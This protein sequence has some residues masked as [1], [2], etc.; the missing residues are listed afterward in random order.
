MYFYGD[1]KANLNTSNVNVN[2]KVIWFLLLLLVHL[3][4]SNVNVNLIKDKIKEKKF[5]H[6]NTSN[7]N[8]NQEH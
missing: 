4:T 7:V 6:L 1:T 8:V 5:K 2:Q 3:N